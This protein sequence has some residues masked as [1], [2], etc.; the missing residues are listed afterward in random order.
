MILSALVLFPILAL[1][2]WVFF[3]FT[4]RSMAATKAKTI[5]T[6]VVAT[7]FLAC[8]GI[9]LWLRHDLKGSTDEPWWPV[10]S[11]LYCSLIVTVGLIVGTLARAR[12][13]SRS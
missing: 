6:V 7:I 3:H 5:N 2:F 11:I 4:P 10:I 13:A 12:A 9:T 8:L 1:A